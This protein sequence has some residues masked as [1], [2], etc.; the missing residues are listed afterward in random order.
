V[1]DGVLAATTSASFKLFVIC[2]FVGW[3]LHSERIPRETAT[4][5][6]KVSE[7]MRTRWKAYLV[8]N[9]LHTATEVVKSCPRMGEDV[10][11]VAGGFQSLHTLHAIHKGS[12]YI[13]VPAACVSA[14]HPNCGNASGEFSSPD[15][16]CAITRH[17]VP[18]H[19][20]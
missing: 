15:I 9:H 17:P 12:I 4:V 5:L 18:G 10:C 7:K 3:L 1:H 14:S 11:M 20:V 8:L 13:V 19:R 2:G 16:L 6:S